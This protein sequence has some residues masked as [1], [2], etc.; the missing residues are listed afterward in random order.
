MRNQLKAGAILSYIALFINSIISILY[1]P[2]MLNLLGQSE[3][4]LYSLAS[5][6]AGFIGILNFGLGN[7]VIRY[8]AKYKALNDEENCSKIYGM[9]FIMY[10]VLGVIALVA[11]IILTLNSHLIFSNSLSVLELKS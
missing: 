5:S 11:G 7:A 4:G 9:F 10:G 3:Y 6:A 8:T 1:T 2:I